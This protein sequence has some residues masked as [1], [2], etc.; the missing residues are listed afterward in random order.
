MLP[1]V[2]SYTSRA[3]AALQL[4]LLLSTVHAHAPHATAQAGTTAT[5]V[6]PLVLAV[7]DVKL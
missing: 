6:A 7:T 2:A 3:I 4:L 1:A 5:A